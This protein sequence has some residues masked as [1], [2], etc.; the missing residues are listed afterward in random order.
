MNVT[1]TG[2]EVKALDEM[3]EILVEAAVRS[4]RSADVIE[5]YRAL[6]FAL[7][8]EWAA[9]TV[10]LATGKVVTL[11]ERIVWFAQG[12][13]S[14][15]GALVPLPELPGIWAG[16]RAFAD[17]VIAQKGPPQPCQHRELLR[18]LRDAFGDKLVAIGNPTK[19]RMRRIDAALAQPCAHAHA[20]ERDGGA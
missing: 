17:K 16:I 9:P 11:A 10:T 14:D 19:E 12:K 4:S 13:L 20:P 6:R 5:H 8:R 3:L 18:E 15:W 7:S 2:D 1:L